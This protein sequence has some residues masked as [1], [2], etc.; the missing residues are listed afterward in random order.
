[1]VAH[2]TAMQPEFSVN[3]SQILP[4]GVYF[5]RFSSASFSSAKIFLVNN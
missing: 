1:M 4:S 3:F 5:A 2:L